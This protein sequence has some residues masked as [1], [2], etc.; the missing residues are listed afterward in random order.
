MGLPELSNCCCLP[1]E[2]GGLSNLSRGP[3]AAM[4]H[5]VRHGAPTRVLENDDINRLLTS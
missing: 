2:L 4:L 3:G 1:A 5:V